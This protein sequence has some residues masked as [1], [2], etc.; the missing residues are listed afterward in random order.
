VSVTEVGD[1]V[2]G[3]VASLVMANARQWAGPA[4]VYTSLPAVAAPP[5]RPSAIR[6]MSETMWKP[7]IITNVTIGTPMYP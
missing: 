7:T 6:S 3:V 2:V 4:C 5:S 1:V